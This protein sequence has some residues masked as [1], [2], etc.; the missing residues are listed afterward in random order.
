LHFWDDAPDDARVI[1]EVEG[2]AADERGFVLGLARAS[3]LEADPP[4]AGPGA[5]RCGVAVAALRRLAPEVRC[6]EEEALAA[7]IAAPWPAGLSRVHPGWLR[8]ALE[9]E[10]GDVIRAVVRD[11]PIEVRR[12]AEE[13]L[14]ARAE[15]PGNPIDAPAVAD[16]QRAV[17]ALLAPQPPGPPTARALC[18]LPLVSLLDEIDGRGA[19]ALGRALS[20]APDAVV[21]R[22]AAGTGE[23]W[24]RVV[25]TAAKGTAPLEARAEAR[26]LVASASG[27]DA[28]RA[29]GLRAVTRELAPEGRAALVAVAQRLPPTVGDALL[30]CAASG[31][32][33]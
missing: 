19:E 11:A 7:E 32:S 18:E 30:T 16:L 12:V 15:P 2:L 27:R 14:A 9:G 22:A 23:R 8:R 1:S 13:I 31:E 33:S 20:G 25:I 3:A 29:I 28:V 6:V 21:A 26:A 10:G 4:L 24:A 17:F 5:E